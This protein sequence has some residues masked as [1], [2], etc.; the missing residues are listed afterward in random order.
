MTPRVSVVKTNTGQTASLAESQLADRAPVTSRPAADQY[1]A[2]R[3]TAVIG[4]LTVQANHSAVRSG[5][6]NSTSPARNTRNAAA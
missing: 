2:P 1:A 5:N 3:K 6:T 4:G